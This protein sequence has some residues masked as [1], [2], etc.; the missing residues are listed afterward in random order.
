MIACVSE[1]KISI[2][3]PN[4]DNEPVTPIEPARYN[5]QPLASLGLITSTI[6]DPI[7]GVMSI[8]WI[9]T[10]IETWLTTDGITSVWT[11]TITTSF[12]KHFPSDMRFP[13]SA[14]GVWRLYSV[15][16][17]HRYSN[18]E[19][20][21]GF[22]LAQGTC[23]LKYRWSLG[24]G[25][26]SDVSWAGGAAAPYA[27]ALLPECAS[28]YCSHTGVQLPTNPYIIT[29]IPP[30]DQWVAV[31]NR[32]DRNFRY[33]IATFRRQPT[34]NLL[35]IYA[36]CMNAFAFFTGGAGLSPLSIMVMA[37][38]AGVSGKAASSGGRVLKPSQSEENFDQY[39]VW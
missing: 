22:Y 14:G 34:G 8:T 3:D 1:D 9:D 30:V 27:H 26:F 17:A 12:L 6:V 10:Q 16:N 2:S 13:P 18:A 4:S 28:D 36:G 37:A 29:S 23:N 21:D 39:G 7:K 5:G 11:E 32:Y 25:N 20:M 24:N 35:P 15:S 38:L 31:G 33:G 19:Q